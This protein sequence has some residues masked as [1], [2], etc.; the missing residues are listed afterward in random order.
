MAEGKELA[1]ASLFGFSKCG[2]LPV[3]KNKK[4]IFV[5]QMHKDEVASQRTEGTRLAYL[6]RREI[7][8]S[9]DQV[10]G[11]YFNVTPSTLPWLLLLVEA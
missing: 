9:M 6:I 10:F 1:L 3:L 2:Y 8:L 11:E 5:A 4:K 7:N